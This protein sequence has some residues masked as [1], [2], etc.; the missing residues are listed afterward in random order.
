MGKTAHQRYPKNHSFKGRK[1]LNL[2]CGFTKFEAKN[3]VNMDK[4]A[5]CEPD[6]VFDLENTPFPFKDNTFD[7]VFANHILE[8]IHNWWGCFEECARVLKPGGSID[9]FVPG[10]G[11]DSQMGY[12]DH[13]SVI[14]KCSFYG[15]DG[16][17]PMKCNAWTYEN[18]MTPASQLRLIEYKQFIIEDGFTKFLPNRVKRWF[19]G[20]LRNMLDEEQYKFVKYIIPE[21][22]ESNG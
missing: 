19:A 10:S 7:Y 15:V 14:N 8:H 21:K 4:Y 18:A 3:V 6:I 12:R 16:Y 2:G 1:V 13:V 11:G 22:G 20:H 5:C 17:N 9:I